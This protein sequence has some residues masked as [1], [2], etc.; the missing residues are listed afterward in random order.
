MRTF[1]VLVVAAA[2]SMLA[3]SLDPVDPNGEFTI[4][5]MA[6]DALGVAAAGQ[7]IYIYK[8][9]AVRSRSNNALQYTSFDKDV[10]AS[11]IYRVT[12]EATGAFEL[13]LS[14]AEVNTDDGEA[15]AYLTAVYFEQG[16]E[17]AF[18][19]TASGWHSFTDRDPLW[20]AGNLQLWNGGT[21]TQ[22]GETVTF[23]WEPAAP[24]SNVPSSTMP[25]FFFVWEF[26][27]DD[28]L[29]KWSAHAFDTS[30]SVP[31]AAFVDPAVRGLKWF[32]TTFS[33]DGRR[34]F[35]HRSNLHSENTGNPV[36]GFTTSAQVTERVLGLYAGTPTTT[37]SG[38][39]AN[40]GQVDTVHE[41]AGTGTVDIF[42][43]IGGET[44]EHILLYNLS[45]ANLANGVIR[46]FA[47][48]QDTVGV[49]CGSEIGAAYS[50]DWELVGQSARVFV[51]NSAGG[52]ADW[53][54]VSIEPKS[55][56]GASPYFEAVSEIRVVD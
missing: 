9:D 23:S 39:D 40:D 2:S 28:F 32:V 37:F 6:F 7:T 3:C 52:T 49:T 51:A 21:A 50:A 38:D 45:V 4:N 14:G 24:P 36:A 16:I 19:A 25:G 11:A 44:F 48:D 13:K 15:A 35:Q 20:E 17:D 1:E 34:E 43:D 56:G 41:F 54:R 55:T 46:S 10:N 33:D 47:C 53:I 26:A 30:A 5:G 42:I 31:R 18:L 29:P 8:V 22:A 27:S 12:A